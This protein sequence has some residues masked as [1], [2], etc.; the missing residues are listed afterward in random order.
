MASGKSML[1]ALVKQ[2][3]EEYLKLSAEDKEDLVKEFGEFRV[4][5][6]V[7]NRVSTKSK[8]N[9]ASHTLR[10]VENEVH[11]VSLNFL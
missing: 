2:N 4:S 5:K 6:T 8:I 1:P 11:L 9:D 10:A 7:G 3:R